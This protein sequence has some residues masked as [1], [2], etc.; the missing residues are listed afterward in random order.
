MPD[1]LHRCINGLATFKMEVLGLC[2]Q[3]LCKQQRG[4]KIL[5][6]ATNLNAVLFYLNIANIPRQK[7]I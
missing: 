3:S 4:K 5:E 7:R 1:F 2:G 6:T